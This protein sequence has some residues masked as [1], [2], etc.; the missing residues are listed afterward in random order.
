[1]TAD[2]KYLLTD[3]INTNDAG[4]GYYENK[5]TLPE[6][7]EYLYSIVDESIESDEAWDRVRGI[8]DKLGNS[9]LTSKDQEFLKQCGINIQPVTSN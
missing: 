4:T 1:M 7:S 9:V 8:A 6:L 2:Q 3:M 5:D